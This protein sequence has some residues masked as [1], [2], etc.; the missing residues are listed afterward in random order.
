MHLSVTVGMQ[1]N[2]IVGPVVATVDAPAKM[3]DVP[4]LRQRQRLITDPTFPHLLQPKVT[5]RP[6]SR[7]GAGHLIR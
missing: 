4:T 3:M 6:S 2:E 1:Q 5:G 7:Q